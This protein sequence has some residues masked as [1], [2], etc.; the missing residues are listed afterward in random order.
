MELPPQRALFI[1]EKGIHFSAIA[2]E[3]I[4]S[5]WECSAITTERSSLSRVRGFENLHIIDSNQDFIATVLI[6]FKELLFSSNLIS[7]ASD[8]HLLKLAESSLSTLEKKIIL[9]ISTDAG[10]SIMTSK[11]GFTR[12]IK[13]LG[14][15]TPKTDIYLD[16]EQLK[17]ASAK[18]V[19]PAM[20]KSDGGG[21]GT[22][23]RRLNEPLTSTHDLADFTPGVIQEFMSL[24]VIGVDAIFNNGRLA[25]WVYCDLQETITPF[26]P[27]VLRHYAAPESLDFV[28]QLQEIGA[29]TGAHGFANC[30]FFYS[31]NERVH[32]IF[33]CDL[34]PNHWARLAPYFGIDV[35]TI[36]SSSWEGEIVTAALVPAGRTVIHF[37]RALT[38]AAD[39]RDLKAFI[40]T[41]FRYWRSS[42]YL[43]GEGRFFAVAAPITLKFLPA[44]VKVI[45]KSLRQYI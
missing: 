25:A 39:E 15:P 43:A 2:R 36:L 10:L 40:R 37:S 42:D 9:P 6:D 17:Q 4:S 27:S 20:I 44:R 18:F 1:C 5:G 32:Y 7:F 22:S 13:E 41:L 31:P 23:V 38:K 12:L 21:G 30:S 28:T 3:L 29:A 45:L 14:L 34:R 26:G 16:V 33:E 8:A 19:L 24:P 11:I 35:A